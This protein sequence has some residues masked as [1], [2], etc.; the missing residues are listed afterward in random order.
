[1]SDYGADSEPDI[2]KAW[3]LIFMKN[4]IPAEK[5]NVM[6]WTYSGRVVRKLARRRDHTNILI[7]QEY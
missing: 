3:D 6:Q 2:S 1:M 4:F 5:V 7:K